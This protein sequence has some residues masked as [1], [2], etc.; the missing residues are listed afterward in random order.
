MKERD[1][2]FPA[3]LKNYIEFLGFD[4]R[5]FSL[6]ATPWHGFADEVVE[7]YGFKLEGVVLE[8]E[9]CKTYTLRGLKQESGLVL[10]GKDFGDEVTYSQGLCNVLRHKVVSLPS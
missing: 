3:I 6:L 10:I 1:F 2:Y 4:K 9:G 5:E 8:G 7:K